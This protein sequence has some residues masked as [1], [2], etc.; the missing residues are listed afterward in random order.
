MKL[1]FVMDLLRK[2]VVRAVRGEREKYQ[3]VHLSSGLLDTSDPERAVKNINPKYI[4][5]A[6]LDR[7]M[8]EGDNIQVINKISGNVEHLMADCGFKEPAELEGLGFD[9]VVGSETFDLRQL[10]DNPANVHYVSLDIKNKFMDASDSFHS[11]EEALEWLNSFNLK[12]VVILTLSKVGTLSL[13]HD[14]FNKAAEISDNP[15]YAGG[16][17]KSLEDI[18]NLDNLGFDGVLIASAFHEGKIDPET[19]KRGKIN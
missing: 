12:G 10:K 17:V 15:L 8:G 16:G 19:I 1:Y 6:D 18:L 13:D 7:I 14:I 2:E 9:G 5:V 4:Y 3:P 11:W